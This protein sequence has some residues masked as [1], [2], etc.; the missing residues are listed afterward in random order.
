MKIQLPKVT[1]TTKLAVLLIMIFVTCDLI[2]LT[3][4]REKRIAASQGL[5]SYDSSQL[6]QYDGS[7]PSKPTMLA[8]DGYVYDISPGRND[9]YQPG[10]PYHDLAGK[11]SSTLLHLVGGE[12]I[13]RKYKIVGVYKP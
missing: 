5:L 9:F 8:L 10:S 1:K 6:A 2:L 13:K 3:R 11:D 12:I 4:L 7:D